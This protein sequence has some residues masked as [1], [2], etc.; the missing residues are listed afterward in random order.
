MS[1]TTFII[2][3]VLVLI[4]GSAG[5]YFV[6]GGKAPSVQ[7]VVD[8]LPF[9][10]APEENPSTTATGATD[11]NEPQT[12]TAGETATTGSLSHFF[13]ISDA[14]IAGAVAVTKNGATFVRYVDRATGHIF[15]VNPTTL[16]KIQILNTT[17]PQIYEA[18]WKQD[19][20]GF[21]ARSVD[22]GSDAITNTSISL[23]AP[24]STSTTSY[25][26]QATLLRGAIDD[27]AISGTSLVYSLSDSGVV[28]TAGFS[29]EKP[30]TIFQSDFTDWRIVPTS[31]AGNVLVFTK[32]SSEAQGY[33][34][35]TSISAGS[36]TKVLGPI[37]ALTGLLSNDAK[38]VLY[39]GIDGTSNVFASLSISGKATTNLFPV[40]LSE[41]CVWGTQSAASVFCGV[42]KGGF[43]GTTIDQWYKGLTHF[44]DQ[45][46]KYD[47]IS[48]T[49]QILF[50]PESTLGMEIDA[51]K[52]VVS[53]KEDYLFVTDK[54]T[55]SLWAL[56]LAR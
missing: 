50:D 9:G 30:R 40:T 26:A 18:L 16:E 3:T 43:G 27:I 39:S 31:G 7:D 44:D 42:P 5:L 55:L 38:R 49:A 1:R 25:T 28:A 4:L 29:G 17:M 37:T 19:G 15:D 33:A 53:P 11:T 48:G 12:T 47:T 36:L 21:I 35:T 22:E 24:K 52:L 8:S 20:S 6:I 41:K 54:T 23:A 13:K 32:A 14:P 51:E 46:W 34:Y 56:K 10:S 2:L 45:I